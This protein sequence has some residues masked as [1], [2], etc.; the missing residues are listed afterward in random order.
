MQ[1][2]IPETG[3]FSKVRVHHTKRPLPDPVNIPLPKPSVEPVDPKTVPIP[4]DARI[5]ANIP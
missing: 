1:M 2:A 5:M 3:Y 4:K